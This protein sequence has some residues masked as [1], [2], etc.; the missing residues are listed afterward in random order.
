MLVPS[1]RV[2]YDHVKYV[3]MQHHVLGN[4]LDPAKGFSKSWHTAL[5]VITHIA[6]PLVSP[7]CSVELRFVT[8]HLKIKY[9]GRVDGSKCA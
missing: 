5:E 9:L 4:T 8:S 7:L 1:K 3:V 2:D 6:F